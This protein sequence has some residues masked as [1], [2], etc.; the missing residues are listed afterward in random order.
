VNTIDP[1]EKV[2]LF[3]GSGIFLLLFLGMLT[4]ML[5]D[6]ARWQ[7][8]R[9]E[10]LTDIRLPITAPRRGVAAILSFF[11]LYP[12][13]LLVAVAVY[14]LK[15]FTG[16]DMLI[17]AITAGLPV[18]V[19]GLLALNGRGNR[20]GMLVCTPTSLTLEVEGERSSLDLTRPFKLDEGSPSQEGEVQILRFHQGSSQWGFTYKLSGRRPS[21][22]CDLKD[23]IPP[24]LDSEAC[25]VHDHVRA[26]LGQLVR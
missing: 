24:F 21:S 18:L 22:N 15:P 5:E 11:V 8:Q 2:R 3:I 26:R 23:E 1:F 25:V 14:G 12:I 4:V 17:A 7:V 20:I 16:H 19:Y 13:L 9:L 10:R 6:H